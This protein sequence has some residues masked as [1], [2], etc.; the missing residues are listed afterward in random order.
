MRRD[1]TQLWQL[2]AC[3]DF[4]AD[5]KGNAGC[6]VK[7]DIIFSAGCKGNRLILGSAR[8]PA[9]LSVSSQYLQQWNGE[10]ALWDS[11]ESASMAD[12]VFVCMINLL[13]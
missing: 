13:H 5:R 2:F 9:F 10:W 1:H 7:I 12:R 11:T 8:K 6:V 4:L 3:R